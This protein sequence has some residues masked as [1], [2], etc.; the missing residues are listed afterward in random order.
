MFRALD[1]IYSMQSSLW[2]CF[3]YKFCRLSNEQ[4]AW[5]LEAPP[6]GPCNMKSHNWFF[7]RRFFLRFIRGD[8][9]EHGGWVGG[10]DLKRSWDIFC[11]KSGGKQGNAS[12]FACTWAPPPPTGLTQPH[13]AKLDT[14][15]KGK[16]T[17][18]PKQIYTISH[19]PTQTNNKSQSFSSW[20]PN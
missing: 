5:Q 10:C 9:S 3:I 20:H 4:E 14:H 17:L 2:S 6:S 15:Q 12:G 19:T 11:E 8:R 13:L 1:V 18:Q 16:G 7:E